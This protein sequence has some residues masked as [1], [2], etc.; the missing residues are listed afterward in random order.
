MG[1]RLV[2][3]EAKAEM[4]TSVE[5]MKTGVEE[6]WGPVLMMREGQNR[7]QMVLERKIM[8]APVP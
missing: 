3:V 1:T 8:Q 5:E 6:R 4:G 7:Y 2:E